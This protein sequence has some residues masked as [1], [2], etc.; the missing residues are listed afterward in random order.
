MEKWVLL[1]GTNCNDP[2]REAEFNKWYDEI[3]LPDIL[4]TPGYTGATRYENSDPSEGQPKFLAA[5]HIETDDIDAVM[6]ANAENVNKLRE[7][8][9]LTELLE[10]VS[11]GLYK[12]ISSV[13]K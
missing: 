3:H 4:K 6:K 8:G 2:A 10:I 5:Y 7:G 9:R 13:S 1:V 12:E 11:R